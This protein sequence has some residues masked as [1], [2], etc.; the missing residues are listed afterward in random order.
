MEYAPII[1]VPSMVLD[2][3]SGLIHDGVFR[4]DTHGFSVDVLEG[5]IAEPAPDSSLMRVSFEHVATTT[6]VEFWVFEGGDLEPRVRGGCEWSFV[7]AG[8]MQQDVGEV[9]MATCVP[10]DP[11]SRRIFGTVFQHHDLVMQVEIHVPNTG[12]LEGKDTAETVVRTVR[13]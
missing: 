3:P 10:L 7:E 13:W 8:R 9:R 12:L 5:W 11:G 4:D 6:R 1:E 2:A